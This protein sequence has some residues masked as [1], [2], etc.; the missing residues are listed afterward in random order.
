ME[1]RYVYKFFL[2]CLTS[3]FWAC[4]GYLEEIPQNKQKLSTTDDYDQLLNN[5]YLTKSVLP[6]IDILTD[7]IDYAVEDRNPSKNNMGDT[8]LGAFMWDHTVETT[9]PN[10][11]PTFELFYNS[12]YNTNVVIE[13]IDDAIGAVLDEE[14]VRHTRGHIK[15]EAYA[16]RA[17]RYLY[18][19]NM[20]AAP[21]DPETCETTPGI[22]IN[23]ETAAADKPYTRAS[24][25]EVYEQIVRDLTTAIP[26]LEEN[27]VNVGK[28]RF[29]AISAKALLARVYL[30]MQEWDLAI[31]QAKDVILANTTLFDL[32]NP[33]FYTEAPLTE[34]SPD[35]VPGSGY[36]N[37]DNTNVLFV[38]GI[39][40]LCELLGG[41]DAMSVFRPSKDLNNAYD[42]G[43][44]RKCYFIRSMDGGKLRYVKHRY[45]QEVVVN[46]VLQLR[47]DYGYSRG[48]RTEEMYL[49]LAEA[50]A[51]KA[52]GIATAVG[53]LNTLREAK[54]RVED[55]ETYGRLHAEDFT[56]QTLLEKVWK[57]RRLE[58]CF[59][60]H[61]WFD[62]RR[63]TRP[64]MTHKGLK[65]TS[66]LQENDPRYVLQI[67]QSELSVNPQIGANPR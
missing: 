26:L 38:N 25:K 32:R 18:L 9:M 2:L 12:A 46:Y 62:L 50:Y 36:L 52:D 10:G 29:S 21:Y 28:T 43:D 45:Y 33:L 14:V 16:L 66:T 49:I 6:Y 64:S 59:E 5:A 30:Y 61:R 22:P 40:E 13:N 3:C 31:E 17:Y 24:L 1:K 20:Y 55:F 53:Y 7:D 35:A 60:E 27:S 11:D 41:N 44:V 4:N 57:E 48:I 37:T 42:Q 39:N 63:T 8:Y 54:F 23:L 19:V 34:W 15:G 51:H 67:P 56:Q 65:G 58:L 47:S